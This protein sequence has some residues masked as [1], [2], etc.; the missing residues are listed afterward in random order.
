MHDVRVL[1]L[2]DICSFL[3]CYRH[4]SDASKKRF[5]PF[6]FRMYLLLPLVLYLVFSNSAGRALARIRPELRFLTLIA[7]GSDH[8]SVLGFSYLR[9]ETQTSAHLGIMVRGKHQGEGI[10][11]DLLEELLKTAEELGVHTIKLTVLVDNEQAIALYHKFGFSVID[12]KSFSNDEKRLLM[13]RQI[14]SS[15]G[16]ELSEREI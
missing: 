10:G 14:S 13:R 11:S 4:R 6:P 3:T 8:N 7:V 1:K 9:W 12:T 5:D 15:G 2:T 16:E